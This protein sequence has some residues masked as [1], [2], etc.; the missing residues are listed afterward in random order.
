MS[1]VMQAYDRLH[2]D[3]QRLKLEIAGLHVTIDA[4]QIVIDRLQTK[5]AVLMDAVR[6]GRSILLNMG[7][8]NTALGVLNEALK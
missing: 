8:S 2:A 6:H 4:Q 1:D 7:V 5:R 3:F